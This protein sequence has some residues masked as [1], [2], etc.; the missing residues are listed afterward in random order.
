MRG[1]FSFLH[2]DVWFDVAKCTFSLKDSSLKYW[3]YFRLILW[4]AQKICG[5]KFVAPLTTY[6]DL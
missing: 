4:R 6:F 2:V 1:K 3:L 5:Y